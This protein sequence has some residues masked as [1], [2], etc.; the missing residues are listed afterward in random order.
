MSLSKFSVGME[1][2]EAI[3]NRSYIVK[4]VVFCLEDTHRARV[5]Q[6]LGEAFHCETL[7]LRCNATSK[8]Q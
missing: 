8:W 4:V 1:G 7:W 2:I 6:R 3:D 5:L